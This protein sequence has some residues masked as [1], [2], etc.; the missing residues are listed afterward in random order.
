MANGAAMGSKYR[1]EPEKKT[2]TAAAK[3]IKVHAE[4]RFR[5]VSADQPRIAAPAA[6]ATHHA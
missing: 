6:N 5:H 2:A 3:K 4:R 1:A